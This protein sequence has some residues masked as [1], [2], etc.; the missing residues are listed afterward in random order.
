MERN[1]PFYSEE[2]KS[3]SQPVS[4]FANNPEAKPGAIPMRFFLGFDYETG[5]MDYIDLIPEKNSTSDKLNGYSQRLV[6]ENPKVLMK[7]AAENGMGRYMPDY[8]YRK[9]L[10]MSGYLGKHV[11]ADQDYMNIFQVTAN[12]MQLFYNGTV[13]LPK[14]E[15]EPCI[16]VQR[17]LDINNIH[18]NDRCSFYKLISR[19]REVPDIHN[20]RAFTEVRLENT[21]ARYYMP[22]KPCTIFLKRR[23]KTFVITLYDPDE[24]ITFPGEDKN[25]VLKAVVIQNPAYFAPERFIKMLENEV[26]LHF[27]Y[28]SE[29]GNEKLVFKDRLTPVETV[30][31]ANGRKALYFKHYEEKEPPKEE[32]PCQLLE[33][34]LKGIP[35]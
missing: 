14:P 18:D 8:D 17:F 30:K 21:D 34:L 9:F 28:R 10:D 1:I 20:K 4:I 29:P 2:Y 15:K 11:F 26:I 33:R 23:Q 35:L 6:V 16:T 24:Y 7:E 19:S 12:L 13:E 22:R 3:T 27:V 31:A 25:N 5:H 32:T